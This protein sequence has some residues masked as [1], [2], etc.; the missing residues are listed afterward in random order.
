[1]LQSLVYRIYVLGFRKSEKNMSRVL[2]ENL[3][4]TVATEN[5][6]EKNSVPYVFS[7]VGDPD[8]D[9][10]PQDPRVL[11]P[12]GAKNLS[13]SYKKNGLGS[14]IRDRKKPIPDSGSTVK[15]EPDPGST[16][17]KSSPDPDPQHW[18]LHRI[19]I[20]NI[21][22]FAGS[23]SATLGSSPD[24]DPQHWGLH[25]IRIPNIGVSPDPEHWRLH[26]ASVTI[27]LLK[28]VRMLP[29]SS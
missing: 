11:G 6:Q 21:G 15:N 1:M 27:L 19:R 10:D 17:L 5:F 29:V 25:Q 12:P 28:G 3:S 8:P 20:R 7:K 16:T 26:V 4:N 13:L 2:R 23:G 18:G 24:P 9:P 22:V 14:E